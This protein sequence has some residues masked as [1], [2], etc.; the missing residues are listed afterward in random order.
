MDETKEPLQVQEPEPNQTETT[1]KSSPETEAKVLLDEFKRLGLTDA[2]DLRNMATASQQTGKAWNEVGQLRKLVDDLTKVNTELQAKIRPTQENNYYGSDDER[3]LTASEFKRMLKQEREN[4][5]NA[6]QT[7]M[8]EMGEIYQHP[9]FKS[10]EN[11]WQ[12]HISDP[13]TQMKLHTGHTTLSKEYYDLV[14]SYYRQTAQKSKEIIEKLIGQKSALPHV[15]TNQAAIPKVSESNER[16]ER[17]DKINK[18]RKAGALKSDD[19][20][21]QMVKTLIDADDPIL[22]S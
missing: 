22:R 19:A 8:R 10:V 14:N 17:L 7:Q 6:Y 2:T 3:P 21:E 11:I 13:G 18:D 1:P 12:R 4:Q 15:E 9:D 16:K 5:L 20:L